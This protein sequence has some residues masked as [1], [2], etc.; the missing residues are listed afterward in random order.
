MTAP[1]PAVDVAAAAHLIAAEAH[2]RAAALLTARDPGAAR[3][4]AQAALD[5]R[6][7]AAGTGIPG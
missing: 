3:R 7:R 1:A 6:A 4:H 2:E 5:S